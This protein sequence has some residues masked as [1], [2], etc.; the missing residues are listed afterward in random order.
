[1]QG[2][3]GCCR[4]LQGVAGCCRVLQNECSAGRCSALQC[5]L[6]R[7]SGNC[8]ASTWT[9]GQPGLVKAMHLHTLDIHSIHYT[10]ASTNTHANSQYHNPI[11]TIKHIISQTHVNTPKPHIHGIHYGVALVSRID[12]IICLFCKRAL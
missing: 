12:K 10:H 2:V 9:R 4:V 3:A 5:L 8:P 11:Q 7:A 1:M 6:K